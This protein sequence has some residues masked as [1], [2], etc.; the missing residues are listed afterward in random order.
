V[1]DSGADA[2][3]GR[4]IEAA[5]ALVS[6]TDL[7]TTLSRVVSAAIE[8]TGARYGALGVLDEERAGLERFIHHGVDETVAAAIGHLPRGRGLLGLLIEDP[9]PLRVEDI[10]SHPRAHGFPAGHPPMSAFLGVPIELGGEPWGNLYL[11]EKAGGAAFNEEDER[12]VVTLA[13][14]AAVAIANA[15]SVAA[16]RLREAMAAAEHERRQWARELHDETLQGLAF[17]RF[18]LGSARDD[19]QR[20]GEIA[21]RML[22]QIDLEITNLRA[23][24]SDLRP[25]SLDEI[26][27]EAALESLAQRMGQRTD[28]ARIEVETSRF[29]RDRLRAP[30][31][32]AIYRVVQEAITNAIR[33]GGAER[34]RVR[35]RRSRGWV[36]VS[37]TDDGGGFD[38][39]DVVPGFG[40]QGMHERA[41]LARGRL[42]IES[43]PGRGTE[44]SLRLPLIRAES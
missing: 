21:P 20:L 36:E 44:V 34:I 13:G 43:E 29:G 10:G 31:E 42:E 2:L 14:W 5:R 6:D 23:L 15:R 12:N 4:L 7:D 39:D 8:I 27:I 30:L 24:I 11:T 38:P 17:L 25:D 16:V 9:Q 32:I 19:P 26:G 18:T 40:L 3:R 35:L 1:E 28:R 41:E 37:V 33:H 22:E